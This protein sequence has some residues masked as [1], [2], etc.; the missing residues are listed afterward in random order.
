ML[1]LC[2]QSLRLVDWQLQHPCVRPQL[3]NHPSTALAPMEVRERMPHYV[4]SRWWLGR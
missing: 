4:Q 2:L 1:T 3:P